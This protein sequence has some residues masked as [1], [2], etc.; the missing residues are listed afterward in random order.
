MPW[1][2]DATAQRGTLAL[3][4][5]TKPGSA[6]PTLARERS[7]VA[8][9]RRQTEDT[10]HT[11]RTA[12]PDTATAQ[13][14]SV[15]PL[16]NPSKL[17]QPIDEQRINNTSHQRL[18]LQIAQ[19]FCP[20]RPT[21]PQPIFELLPLSLILRLESILAPAPPRPFVCVRPEQRLHRPPSRLQTPYSR[22]QTAD[23]RP[24]TSDRS[25]PPFQ[26]PPNA[27][28]SPLSGITTCSSH[29]GDVAT[30]KLM[31][32]ASSVFHHARTILGRVSPASARV[33]AMRQ[34][35]DSAP[36]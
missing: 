2:R 33:A 18:H 29:A 27:R 34:T 31:V 30:L 7:L 22:L 28:S 1:W 32:I 20:L 16:P 26:H 19:T 17:P 8:S 21:R 35:S 4:A 5:Q 23:L 25:A 11:L 9:P 36:S 12:A 6:T 10:L 3:V 13:N 24:Q 14:L 15:A